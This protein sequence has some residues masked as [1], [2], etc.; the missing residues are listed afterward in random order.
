M[1]ENEALMFW[2]LG[3]MSSSTLKDFRGF[4]HAINKISWSKFGLL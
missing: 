3:D 2:G 1:R 4:M